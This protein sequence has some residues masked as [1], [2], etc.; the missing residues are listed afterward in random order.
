M[1]GMIDYFLTWKRGATSPAEHPL[2]RCETVIHG[3]LAQTD[4]IRA[5]AAN[6]DLP[7][8]LVFNN[9]HMVHLIYIPVGAPD[10]L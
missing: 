4:G 6:E 8:G 7:Q 3:A 5:I 1:L 9:L 10:S 2:F